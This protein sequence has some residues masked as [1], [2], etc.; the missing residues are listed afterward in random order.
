MM[1]SRTELFRNFLFMV[2]LSNET[3]AVSVFYGVEYVMGRFELWQCER[4][5]GGPLS[6]ISF[7]LHLHHNGVGYI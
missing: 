5:W 4:I 6:C 2:K 3:E 1:A 7:D